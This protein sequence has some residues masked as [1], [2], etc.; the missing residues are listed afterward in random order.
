MLDKELDLM[1]RKKITM[2]YARLYRKATT[3]KEKSRLLTEFVH[4]TGYNRSYAS[5]LLRNAGKK[6][7]LKSPSGK[8]VIIV[9]DPCRKVK[10]RR[11]KIYDDEVLA[12][13][14]EVWYVLDYPCSL[15]LKAALADTIAQMEKHGEI[16]LDGVVKEKLLRISKA[17]IDRLLSPAVFR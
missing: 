3:K 12:A 15:R 4:I 16:E 9:A 1:T 6:V 7:Y 2:K 5:W 11:K 10:R 14:K 17:T 8:R 13:L